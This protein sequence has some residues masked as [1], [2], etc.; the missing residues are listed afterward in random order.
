MTAY[1][2]SICVSPSIMW[3]PSNS[4][5]AATE[6]A[7]GS[8]D[9]VCFL[10][11]NYIDIF[12]KDNEYLLGDEADIQLDDGPGED[13]DS[14]TDQVI[15][16]YGDGDER[17]DSEKE[18]EPPTPDFLLSPVDDQGNVFSQSDSSLNTNDS[19]ELKTSINS[20]LGIPSI[21]L[22]TDSSSHSTPASPLIR[23]H[24]GE[25]TEKIYSDV[26][27]QEFHESD[28]FKRK[29]LRHNKPK[30]MLSSTTASAELIEHKRIISESAPKTFKKVDADETMSTMRDDSFSSIESFSSPSR[31]STSLAGSVIQK[32]TISQPTI[33]HFATDYR[34]TPNIIFH[35][36][37][38]RRLP[39]AP[40]YEEHIQRTQQQS[41][42]PK[43]VQS[44]PRRQPIVV[45][46]TTL[47]Q[48][49]SSPV[50]VKKLSNTELRTVNV[51]KLSVEE[52]PEN[53]MTRRSSSTS[54]TSRTSVE[55]RSL[56]RS[57]TNSPDQKRVGLVTRQQRVSKD[58]RPSPRSPRSQPTSPKH[59]DARIEGK[60]FGKDN[61][62]NTT[63]AATHAAEH[64]LSEE[65][66]T[67]IKE[68]LQNLTTTDENDGNDSDIHTL[69]PSS[70]SS[71]L[72]NSTNS[73][74]DTSHYHHS[75]SEPSHHKSNSKSAIELTFDSMLSDLNHNVELNGK[76]SNNNHVKKNNDS[77]A[78]M[79]TTQQQEQHS[80]VS[81]STS[82]N[83]YTESKSEF[84]ESDM[85][86][87]KQRTEPSSHSNGEIVNNNNLAS[88]NC[89]STSPLT[90][91]QGPFSLTALKSDYKKS[92]V[93]SLSD[94]SK[95]QSLSLEKTLL[96]KAPKKIDQLT[97]KSSDKKD[98]GRIITARELRRANRKL[99]T[100]IRNAFHD[101][102][103]L[104]PK[105]RPLHVT[106]KF[107]V[108][109]NGFI[110]STDV[111]RTLRQRNK[112]NYNKTRSLQASQFNNERNNNTISSLSLAKPTIESPFNTGLYKPQTGI[113]VNDEEL[114]QDEEYAKIMSQA[115]SYV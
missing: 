39:A 107:N 37:D 1:N 54:N 87:C 2:L 22:Q 38:R 59:S 49:Q 105:D 115:E 19:D 94:D 58:D 82:M 12:S 14:G 88:I 96:T 72:K 108:K 57:C 29:L 9:V 76:S 101:G 110:A 7:T 44:V 113:I 46:H 71:H 106:P 17:D 64:K 6:Q 92:T 67:M 51:H 63:T 73:L 93:N 18:N 32:H 99:K 80:K 23:R 13:S 85:N 45:S 97:T 90:T 35:A 4:K 16:R 69:E 31:S 5:L 43:T 55:D 61:D 26:S 47:V 84:K 30:R 103:S 81:N 36:V 66:N 65:E 40:S 102:F 79:S 21:N 75:N 83:H 70:S 20:K 68:L 24:G 100:D 114:Q 89:T 78:T 109:Y 3:P 28:Q 77:T 62:N 27:D 11:D 112:E 60:F 74:L 52:R 41:F 42:K 91:H 104:P 15:Y 86:N 95:S 111:E 56:P 25:K 8:S 53:H 34:S 50:R 33:Q 98:D 48:H 10:I